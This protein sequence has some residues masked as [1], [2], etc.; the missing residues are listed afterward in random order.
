MDIRIWCHWWR[1]RHSCRLE[2]GRP[3]HV[4]SYRVVAAM[5]SILRI[6]LCKERISRCSLRYIESQGVNIQKK[7]FE[8]LITRSCLTIT[9]R[10]YRG[11]RSPQV[12]RKTTISH[13]AHKTSPIIDPHKPVPIPVSEDNGAC[14]QTG[15]LVMRCPF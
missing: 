3:S 6:N 14:T 13:I 9:F 7:D 11:S 10:I 4:R 8:D 1:L 12:P 5:L 2:C 15:R